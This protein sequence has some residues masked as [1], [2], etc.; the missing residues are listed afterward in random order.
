[1][2][3]INYNFILF[4]SFKCLSFLLKIK[5]YIR[6]YLYLFSLFLNLYL[7]IKTLQKLGSLMNFT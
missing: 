6:M 7:N 3:T 1:M 5:N 2:L 4:F